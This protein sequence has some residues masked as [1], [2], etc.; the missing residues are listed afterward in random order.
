MTDLDRALSWLSRQHSNYVDIIVAAYRAEKERADKAE[1]DCAR[2][3]RETNN[4]REKVMALL[5]H[6]DSFSGQEEWHSG[7]Y[8]GYWS[9]SG[10]MVNTQF[11]ADVRA[12]LAAIA[13]GRNRGH[14]EQSFCRDYIC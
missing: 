5:D 13:E 12:A 1:A 14:E 2:V 4:L 8:G 11:I 10:Q 3:R 6:W 9:P 7:P